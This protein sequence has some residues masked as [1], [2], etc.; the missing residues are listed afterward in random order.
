M[1]NRDQNQQFERQRGVTPPSSSGTAEQAK[2]KVGE[3][4]DQVQEKAGEVK[5]Q[6]TAQATSKIEQGKGQAV[7]S[8]GTV[9]SAIRQTSGQL[10]KQDQD[11][12]AEYVERMAGR[13][14]EF[15][16]YLGNRNLNQLVGDAE[17]FARRE[18]A[19]FVGG[20]FLLGLFGARFL[21][22]SAQVGQQGGSGGSSALFDAGYAS[23]AQTM[24]SLPSHT[25]PPSYS[26]PRA[27]GAISTGT[28]TPPSRQPMGG[29]AATG[30]VIVGGP[31]ISSDVVGGGP[32]LDKP[33][34]ERR[35]GSFDQG[36]EKP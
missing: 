23:T 15:G 11:G 7:D 25:T 20:S 26:T 22:S 5:D 8:L 33:A 18:P 2:E 4:K 28:Q 17:R 1:V 27:G 16:T 19:L 35:L 12:I 30:D 32:P 29:A 9:A 13:I 21:K 10:R 34:G 14:E 3:V 24:P 36:R 31:P 6:V